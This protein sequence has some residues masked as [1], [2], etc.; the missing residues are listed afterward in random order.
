M[1]IAEQDQN[2]LGDNEVLI[3]CQNCH[4]MVGRIEAGHQAD[5]TFIS[6]SDTLH[7]EKCDKCCP[8]ETVNADSDITLIIIELEQQRRKMIG[9]D[10]D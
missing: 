10:E 1:D 7:C 2:V 3:F 6:Q 8:E 9:V 5:G 4:C